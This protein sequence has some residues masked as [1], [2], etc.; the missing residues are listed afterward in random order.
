MPCFQQWKP[1]FGA[2]T[3]F[4]DL[5]VSHELEPF[6][7]PSLVVWTRIYRECLWEAI[8]VAADYGRPDFWGGLW[9]NQSITNPV[10]MLENWAKS[11]LGEG[12]KEGGKEALRRAGCRSDAIPYLQ[13]I[14]WDF[15]GCSSN[16]IS[17]SVLTC[18]AIVSTTTPFHDRP[19]DFMNIKSLWT[20]CAV[21]F[22]FI[23][24]F[25]LLFSGWCKMNWSCWSGNVRVTLV[26]DWEGIRTSNCNFWIEIKVQT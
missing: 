6:F 20:Q 17:S 2:F 8:I 19:N 14:K 5:L 9:M 1:A 12:K 13:I 26:Y 18:S 10:G 22:S 11:K 16:R 21:G 15:W 25:L 7:L 23:A 4:F 24:V 3:V